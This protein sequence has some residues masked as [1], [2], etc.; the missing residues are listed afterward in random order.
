MQIFFGYLQILKS[1]MVTS[2]IKGRSLLA[3]RKVHSKCIVGTLFFLHNFL[4]TIHNKWRNNFLLWSWESFST[5]KQKERDLSRVH[6]ALDMNLEYNTRM[7]A[8]TQ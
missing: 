3:S 7:L 5:Q 1:F 2:S 4:C 6:W 8:Y